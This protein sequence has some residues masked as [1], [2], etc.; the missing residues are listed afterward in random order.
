MK[1]KIVQLFLLLGLLGAVVF[2]QEQ[3]KE[4]EEV[5]Q[6]L[7]S[8]G[9][10]KPL[11]D[12]RDYN[13][14]YEG[15]VGTGSIGYVGGTLYR[16]N[17][18]NGWRS[19]CIGEGCGRHPGVDIPVPIGTKAYS[20]TWGQVVIS[21]C[22][23]EWGGLL[24]LRSN[25]PWTGEVVYITYAHL[26]D[27]AYS[28]GAPVKEGHWVST[29]VQIGRTGGDPNIKCSGNSTGAHL[30]FQIDRDDGNPEPWY[31][32]RSQ[33]NYPDSN[34]Q[35]TG[36]T[37]NPIVFLTGGYRWTFARNNDRE[38]WDLFNI[39]SWGVSDNALWVDAG[40]DPYIRRGGLTNCG[41]MKPCSSNIAAEATMFRN[42]Y[43][44]LYNL[45]SSGLG[46]V[47]FTT[48]TS[49]GWDEEKSVPYSA[50]YGPQHTHVL[51][52]NNGR[53]NG[54]ITGLRIDPSES[55]S[56]GFDPTYYGEITVER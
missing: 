47:Y 11:A 23:P 20:A 44:D 52:A 37:F 29:G 40:N 12:L 14:T 32:T 31:P 1:K 5:Q 30:H 39:Q 49:P 24:V 6:S 36:K 48:N 54:I 9:M 53:W 35:V 10:A 45:C 18:D 17:Q 46:K 34:Y 51:M 16:D 27:R 2:G 7:P 43:L 42:V 50:S 25:S 55:C 4:Q 28:N 13:G 56:A 26:S 21:R 15:S 22:D 19:G 41:R 38:L 8:T 3:T 33:L